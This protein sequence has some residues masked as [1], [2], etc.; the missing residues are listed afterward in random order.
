MTNALLGFI[1]GVSITIL[2]GV[3]P[4]VVRGSKGKKVGHASSI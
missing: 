3:W 2:L 1:L 4:Y